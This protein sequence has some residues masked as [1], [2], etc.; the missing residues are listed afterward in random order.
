MTSSSSPN[1]DGLQWVAPI[2]RDGA[3]VS[4]RLE[5]GQPLPPGHQVVDLVE[6]DPPAEPA[7]RA[8]DLRSGLGVVLRP[9]LGQHLHAVAAAVQ[10]AAQH[11]LGLAVHGRGVEEVGAGLDGLGHAI[12]RGGFSLRAM[13]VERLPRPDAHG[14]D[15]Q[16]G[17]CPERGVPS[18]RRFPGW[19]AGRPGMGG[20]GAV[21]ETGTVSET[22]EDQRPANRLAARDQ[23]LPAPARPQPGRLVPLG[24]RRRSARAK[25]RT[26][27]SSSRSATRRAT[28]AT[29][30]SASRSRTRRSPR[31]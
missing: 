4:Q 24:R 18:R 26:S 22:R 5:R 9:D 1:A 11:P 3:L 10:S 19:G 29:S 30:W 23:P 2:G 16:S 8:V 28:G 7:E 20:T 13:H 17:S 25:P 14:G 31:S 27:R 12:P 15:G 21:G 6:V